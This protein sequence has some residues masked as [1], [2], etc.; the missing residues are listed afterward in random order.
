MRVYGFA[1]SGELFL[2]PKRDDLC[3]DGFP[4]IEEG[5][6]FLA[7]FGILQIGLYGDGVPTQTLLAVDNADILECHILIDGIGDIIHHPFQIFD[8]IGVPIGIG[9]PSGYDKI[10]DANQPAC[11]CFRHEE[12]FS[13]QWQIPAP[14][15]I[16]STISAG[17]LAGFPFSESMKIQR[18]MLSSSSLLKMFSYQRGRSCG[19]F[20]SGQIYRS[21]S[22]MMV[23]LYFG[24]R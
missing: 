6:D 11:R 1:K 8:V 14:N 4:F 20:E 18:E 7:V 17:M 19:L 12:F 9:I 13:P 5:F 3:N 10:S 23:S 16:F 15:D 24:I 21:R 2:C 22:A